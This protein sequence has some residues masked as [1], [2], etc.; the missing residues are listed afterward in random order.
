MFQSVSCP[1]WVSKVAFGAYRCGMRIFVRLTP[2][3]RG[4]DTR[5]H[6]RR[7]IATISKQH[8]NN[9]YT[10]VYTIKAALG[11]S[12]GFENRKCSALDFLNRA[13]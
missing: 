3:R 1:V 10:L 2:V 9:S 13:P 4:S 8:R 11:C 5:Q 12:R 6:A 7:S